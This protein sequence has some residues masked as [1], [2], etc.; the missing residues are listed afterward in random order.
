VDPDSNPRAPRLTVTVTDGRGRRVADGGLARWLAQVAPAAA[1]GELAIALVS[2]ARMIAL[3]RTYRGKN[4][5][6]DVLSFVTEDSA[7]RQL[8][9]LAIAKGVAV[10]QAREQGHSY[11]TELRVLALHGLLHLLG[12]DHDSLNDHGRMG[13]TEARL[14]RKGGLRVGLIARAARRR[15]AA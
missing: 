3:N 11:Q 14:R 8:G 5:P 6:T 7:S 13:R 4:V 9:D 12:Y 15:R 10:R 1:R 2:D